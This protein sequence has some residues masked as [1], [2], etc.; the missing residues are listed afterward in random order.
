MLLLL[1]YTAPTPVVVTYPAG[2]WRGT[3]WIGHPKVAY[4]TDGALR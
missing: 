4:P 1:L 2:Y 3:A